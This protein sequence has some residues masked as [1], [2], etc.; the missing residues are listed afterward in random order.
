MN[1]QQQ[2]KKAEKLLQ[3]GQLDPAIESLQNII[4]KFPRQSHAHGLLGLLYIFKKD[5]ILAKKHLIKSLQSDFNVGVAKNLTSL[6]IQ[7]RLWQDAYTWSEKLVLKAFSDIEVKL[8]HA[9]ILRNINKIDDAL[10]LYKALLIKK[11]EYIKTYISYGFTLN[12]LERYEAA[13]EVYHQGLKIQSKEF[14]LLY[15]LGIT[16]LNQFDYDNALQYMTLA[17]NQ[18]N[19]SVNLWLTI[20]VCYAKKRDLDAA[21]NS[22]KE[23]EKI[24]PNNL[25]VPF[26]MGTFLIQQDRNEEAMDWLN[27]VINKEPEH[28]EANYHIGLIYL[29]KEKYQEAVQYYRYR[30]KRLNQRFG[31]FNDFDLPKLTKEAEVIISWEQGIGDE[32]L[33]LGLLKNIR[34]NIKSITYI[35]QDKLFDW[36]KL[37]LKGIKVIKETESA[38]YLQMNPSLIQLNIGSL[39]AYIEN[40]E[41]YFKKPSIC[42]VDENLYKKYLQKYK[43][44]NEKILGISWRSANKK[45]GDEK[46]I[47]LNQ[48]SSIISNQ[49]TISLQ[50]GDVQNEINKVNQDKSLNIIH[51]DELDYFNDINSLAALI[52]ICDIVV[53]CSNVTAHIAGRLGIKTYLMIPKFFGNIW[54]WNESQHQSRWY[55]SVTIIKQKID[56]SWDD[57]IQE[58]KKHLSFVNYP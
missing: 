47:P 3:V 7:E 53:T 46:S 28:I 17:L 50:Y 24:D 10:D 6:L 9:L 20:A 56:M 44:N 34:K 36:I 58:V 32:I 38:N 19:Q 49:K 2:I 41:D 23:A 11:P 25:L 42:K 4:T 57:P 35:T 13:A 39:M 12:L 52:S 37:N 8:N 40:W 14:N 29:K 31:K 51:D 45:I 33:Y 16:Y 27:K 15:N 18:N 22:I 54:Y 21:F 30:T 5:Y 26:Q 1:I 48:L 43:I 55:P